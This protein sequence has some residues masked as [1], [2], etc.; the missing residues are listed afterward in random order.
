MVLTRPIQREIDNLKSK[1]NTRKAK[2]ARKASS[3][4]RD[5]LINDKEY[6][7]IRDKNPRVIL[8]IDPSW[9]PC[10]DF[11]TQLDYSKVDDELVGCLAAFSRV[12]PSYD[13]K[14][15]THDTGP[16][17]SAKMIGLK[18]EPIPEDWL[19]E[20]EPDDA[21]RKISYLERENNLLRSKEPIFDISCC[22]SDGSSFKTLK[23][24]QKVF[25]P[26]KECEITELLDLLE[27]R[28]PAEKNFDKDPNHNVQHEHKLIIAGFKFVHPSDT[29]INKYINESYPQWIN[30]CNAF[31]RNIHSYIQRRDNS[32]KFD[33]RVEN[34]G[35][36]PAKD[37]LVEIKSKGNIQFEV[38]N[39]YMDKES[40][41]NTPLKIP[42]PPQAPCGEW[43]ER[44][45]SSIGVF[46]NLVMGNDYFNIEENIRTS[47]FLQ[48]PHDLNGFYWKPQRPVG[49]VDSCA[50]ECVQ[51]R[52][53]IKHK[54]FTINI[55]AN[56][57]IPEVSGLVECQVHAENLHRPVSMQVPVKIINKTVSSFE[58]AKN[59]I[60]ELNLGDY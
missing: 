27:V 37:A 25:S 58:K 29:E 39:E 4:L 36:I 10:P 42:S 46:S 24:E 48:E 1:G 41:K 18:F 56:Q 13:V 45:V 51:W 59:L 32:L 26:L 3:L 49:P 53:G 28:F 55:L 34:T 38:P 40:G 5:L 47:S 17:S 52:H 15:L 16:M 11:A 9:Q 20:P 30:E 43:K 23:V 54:E 31:F 35:R 44:L 19:L 57:S 50:L 6:H 7:I 33:F 60:E 14:L 12:H 2:H 22:D 8:R 21:T